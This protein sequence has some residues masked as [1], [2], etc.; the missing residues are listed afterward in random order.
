MTTEIK[1]L[2]EQIA[3]KS[4]ALHQTMVI[5]RERAGSLELE[6]NRLRMENTDLKDKQT[7]VDL[8]NQRLKLE[9]SQHESENRV[10][11]ESPV[12]DSRIDSLVQ[13]IDFCIQQ[14]KIANE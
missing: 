9:I 4:R 14:L 11:V 6:I 8:E 7:Q 13:E 5:E 2:I 12:N 10:V 1:T 3:A